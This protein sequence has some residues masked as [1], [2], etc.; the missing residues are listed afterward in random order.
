MALS[1]N[2]YGLERARL[3]LDAIARDRNDL[4]LQSVIDDILS[5]S[6][7]DSII[8]VDVST[9]LLSDYR[10]LINVL[11]HYELLA[12]GVLS[13]AYDEGIYR[14]DKQREAIRVWYK[15][16]SFIMA[17]RMEAESPSLFQKYEYLV[18]RWKEAG[19]PEVA[20]FVMV[21]HHARRK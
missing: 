2:R 20:D 21:H 19:A 11:N 6:E 4:T 17:L 18:Q 12:S 1:L 5:A 16:E 9:T 7:E 13:G 10:P 8:P 14:A 15:V 3:T